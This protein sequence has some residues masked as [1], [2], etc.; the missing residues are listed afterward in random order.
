MGIDWERMRGNYDPGNEVHGITGININ[1]PDRDL[2]EDPSTP[3]LVHTFSDP[4]KRTVKAKPNVTLLRVAGSKD[5]TL[6][7]T[8]KAGDGMEYFI[9]FEGEEKSTISRIT[10]EEIPER[11]RNVQIQE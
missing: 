8:K 4:D 5:Q 1:N 7:R 2:F 9:R 11:F 10:V 6:Y 3:D